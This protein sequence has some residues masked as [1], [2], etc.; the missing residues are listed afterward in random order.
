[1]IGRMEATRA[2]AA[3]EPSSAASLVEIRQ[4]TRRERDFRFI[5]Q[6]GL[7]KP[8]GN[9]SHSVYSFDLEGW[10]I[11]RDS[12]FAQAELLLD[13][14]RLWTLP[15]AVERPDVASR[16]GL[17]EAEHAIGFYGPVN[18][19]RLPTD[20]E[21]VVVAVVEDGNRMQIADIHGTRAPLVSSFEPSLRPLMVT[22]LGRT[23]SSM[24][25]N[26]LDAHPEIVAYRPLDYEPRALEYWMDAFLALA[27]PSSYLNQLDPPVNIEAERLWWLGE[28]RPAPRKTSYRLGEPELGRW[29]GTENLEPSRGHVPVSRSGP[30]RAD[31]RA[32]A[33]ATPLLR[34]EARAE[35][36]PHTRRGAVPGYA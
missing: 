14:T 30:V 21:C 31:R 13:D 36:H 34:R 8:R 22:T 4:I 15:A 7:E 35:Q 2:G 9:S 1:M 27:E 23:G 26:M 32:S 17:E 5:R 6:H 19:L 28:E 33:Q 25:L 12:R 3:G 18:A 11:G 29:M 16:Y 20:F 10:A 24:L